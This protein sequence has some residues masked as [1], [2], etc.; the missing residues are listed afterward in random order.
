MAYALG[1]EHRVVGVTTYCNY[2]PAAAKK[3][4]VGAATEL[5]E[6]LAVALKPDLIVAVEGDRARLERLGKLT[7]AKVVVLKTQRVTD[8]WDNMRTLGRLTG[9]AARAE[10]EVKSRQ[11][12]LKAVAAQA[13]QRRT[14]PT[15]FYM[16]WDQP[17]MTAG[18]DSYLDDLIT[19]AGGKNVVGAMPG[20]S[21]PSYS[22]ELLLAKNPQVILGPQNM[23]GALHTLRGS[24]PHLRAVKA[25]KLRT[26]PDDLISR[27]GPRVV[28]ALE[29]VSAA[30]R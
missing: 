28:E 25:D 5:N 9:T 11:A 15:V 4:R 29:A 23:R 2:P 27:P 24:Y 12:R 18:A 30:L 7:G 21:Y 6:E 20:G 19:L 26:L 13:A 1:L 10:Q 8:I 14:Q 3:P 17:L 22:W 16:V